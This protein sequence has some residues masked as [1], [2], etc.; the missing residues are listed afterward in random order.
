MHENEVLTMRKIHK[1]IDQNDKNK[2]DDEAIKYVSFIKNIEKQLVELKIELS[3]IKKS[4]LKRI[5][6]EFLINDYE[7]RFNIDQKGLISAII[8]E[9]YVASE[10]TRQ[11]RDQKV[12]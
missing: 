10:Y 11:L 5:N 12:F 4:E 6:K 1:I 3:D 9:D 2:I 7:R 8:G